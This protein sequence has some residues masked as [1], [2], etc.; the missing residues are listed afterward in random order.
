V[1][2]CLEALL[3]RKRVEFEDLVNRQI[4]ENAGEI[5]R[6]ASYGDLSENS[7]WSAA[8]EKQERLTRQSEELASE[9]A[10]ARLIQPGIADGSEVTLGSRV[11]LRDVEGRRSEFT[12]LGPWELDLDRGYISY[13]SPMGKALLHRKVGDQVQVE[14]RAGH[15]AYEILDI[16]DGLSAAERSITSGE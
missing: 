12:I 16:A 14:G 2:Y 6:A 3:L 4:P 15:I 7:E 5:G 8:I 10:K 11:I 9:L 13:L 1:L